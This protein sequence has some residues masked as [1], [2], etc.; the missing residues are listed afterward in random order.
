MFCLNAS[1]LIIQFRI[2][3]AGYAEDT[4]VTTAPTGEPIITSMELDQED[5]APRPRGTLLSAYEVSQVQKRKREMREAYLEH[6]QA[7][8]ELTGTG[9]PVDMIISPAAPY[10]APLHGTNRWA[11]SPGYLSCM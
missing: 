4:R 9:R 1:I 8:F 2:M 10:A 6:W 3:N 7:T 11:S 5:A